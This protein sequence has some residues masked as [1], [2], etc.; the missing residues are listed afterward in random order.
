MITFH[1]TR[2]HQDSE[3]SRLKDPLDVLLGVVAEAR[4]LIDDHLLLALPDFPIVELAAQLDYWLRHGSD[5]DFS[6]ESA[7]AE[8]EL[9]WF[10]RVDDRWFAGSDLPEARTKHQTT[11]A[12]AREFARRYIDR[13]RD[14]VKREMRID[15]A[16]ALRYR[17]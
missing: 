7:E 17:K 16:P 6:Y 11:R 3:T 15:V 10:R 9:L 1:F 13:V 2:P 8:D 12:A 4:F 14:A 5:R